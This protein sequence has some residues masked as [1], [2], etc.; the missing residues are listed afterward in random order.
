M[1]NSDEI[2]M[3]HGPWGKRTPLQ[4][5]AKR[6]QV[7]CQLGFFWLPSYNKSTNTINIF[8]NEKISYEIIR[9]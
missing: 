4:F 3:A 5:T 1:R 9:L 8:A 7:K 2:T 6:N